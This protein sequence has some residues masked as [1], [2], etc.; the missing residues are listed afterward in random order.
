MLQ[1]P[2]AV[3]D[4]TI[5]CMIFSFRSHKYS[6]LNISNYYKIIYKN[7]KFDSTFRYMYYAIK[8]TECK[9]NINDTMKI[10]HE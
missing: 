5:E 6:V 4:R 7:K 9:I 3:T 2:P 8:N 10:L 1:Y